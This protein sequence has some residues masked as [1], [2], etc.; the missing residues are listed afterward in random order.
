MSNK[1]SSIT[2]IQLTRIGDIIQT[3]WAVKDIKATNPELKLNFIARDRFA[4]GLMFL[5]EK[6]FDNIYLIKEDEFQGQDLKEGL[7]NL[8]L[9]V[10]GWET[11]VVVNLSFSKTSGFL[12]RLIDADFKLGLCA[13]EIGGMDVNGSWSEYVYSTVMRGPMNAFSLVD[14]FRFILGSKEKAS[15]PERNLGG[16]EVIVHPFASQERKMWSSSKW[17]EIIFKIL[18]KNESVTVSIVGGKADSERAKQILSNPLLDKYSSRIK[19]ECGSL[20]FEELYNRLGKAFLFCGHDS[21]VGHLA[22]L[23]GTQTLTLSLGSVRPIESSPYGINNYVLSPK[24]S[25][26]PCFPTDSCDSYK[27]HNDLSYQLVSECLQ[28]LIDTS[29]INFSEIKQNISPMHL[30]TA[31]LFQSSFSSN[32]IFQLDRLTNE[33]QST[34]EFY[35]VFYKIVWLFMLE[36]IEQVA[37]YPALNKNLE[38]SINSVK[39]NIRQLFELAEFGKKYSKFI[40][41]ELSKDKP[42]IEYIKSCGDKIAEIDEMQVLVGKACPILNPIIDFYNLKKS[43]MSG[44]NL[45]E[46]CSSSYE[47][48]QSI[49]SFTDIFHE[50]IEKTL[51]ENKIKIRTTSMKEAKE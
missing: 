41:E 20:S 18:K 48:Y 45:V 36:D 19:I 43:K 12:T 1:N 31:D 26:F 50:L 17:S 49:A 15:I 32:G 13:N 5:L 33:N 14:I 51:N 11:S 16:N 30:S 9:K 37:G 47:I 24:T 29:S 4:N 7:D 44:G 40:L 27:C 10:K 35:K 22:S 28:Q 3:I 21:M 25:C 42:D 39:P 38:E 46:L 6:Y 23:A 2:V 34:Q 8:L